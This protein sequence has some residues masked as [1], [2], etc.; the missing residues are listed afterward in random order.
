[1]AKT[2]IYLVRHGQSIG[3]LTNIMLGHADLD[4]SELG[5]RQADMTAE[6]LRKIKIDA[7]YSSDLIRASNTALPHAKIRDIEVITDSNLRELHLGDWEN[8]DKSVLREKFGENFLRGWL[9]NFGIFTFPNG[10]SVQG[11]AERFYTALTK[12]ARKHLG[13]TVLVASHAAVIRT[14]WGKITG[15]PEEKWAGETVFPSNASYTV[16]EYDGE[17]FI[18]VSFSNDEHLGELITNI[19][20]G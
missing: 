17:K 19:K 12:I 14:F 2:T 10:E 4:L 8:Q 9:D 15:L 1:M 16:V 5:Y 20:I 18:P 13:R 6:A 3:N 11:G 7:I